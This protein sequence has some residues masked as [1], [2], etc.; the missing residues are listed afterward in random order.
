M[1]QE[2]AITPEEFAEVSVKLFDLGFFQ[3]EPRVTN[4]TPTL[5]YAM[6]IMMGYPSGFC[7]LSENCAAEYISIEPTGCVQACDR[8]AGNIEL[9]FGNIATSSLQ[10]I[11]NSPARQKFL[12]RWQVISEKCIGCEWTSI[13]HGGCPHDAYARTGTI[14]ERDPNCGAYKRIF[15]HVARTISAQLEKACD[16]SA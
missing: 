1:N 7:V 5:H 6:A 9:T 14:F 4:V 8:F 12:G 3:P 10:D 15:D 11:L 2:L 16:K 13:C